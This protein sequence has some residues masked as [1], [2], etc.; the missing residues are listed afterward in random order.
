MD[1]KYTSNNQTPLCW[2]A[3]NGH[4]AFIK[5]LL[6]TGEVDADSKDEAGWTPLALAVREGH[7][8]VVKLSCCSIL[9]RSMPTRRTDL[10]GRRD[11]A[12]Q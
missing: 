4:E 5:L 8:A 2:A 9:Q 11:Y 6:N 12:L 7:E 3:E 10:V 1:A